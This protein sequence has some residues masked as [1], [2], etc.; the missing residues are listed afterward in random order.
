MCL[1]GSLAV[2]VH[3][4]VDAS[5]GSQCL[6]CSVCDP[7]RFWCDSES[8]DGT[9][10]RRNPILCRR[11][12]VPAWNPG[13]EPLGDDPIVDR[14]RVLSARARASGMKRYDYGVVI[15]ACLGARLLRWWSRCSW[16][17]R[18]RGD[19]LAWPRPWKSLDC[20]GRGM[21]CRSTTSLCSE[22]LRGAYLGWHV[23]LRSYPSPQIELPVETGPE[24]ACIMHDGGRLAW[25][26][27]EAVRPR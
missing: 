2:S 7:G 12:G 24:S 11:Y 17:Q 21:A 6:F 8:P 13:I 14:R 10:S 18:A 25:R 9:L 3:I 1:R 22:A 16:D 23:K 15:C 26:G 20:R 19:S 4:W 5:R 27:G